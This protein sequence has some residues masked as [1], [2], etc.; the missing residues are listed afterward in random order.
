V[1]DCLAGEFAIDEPAG[2]RTDLFPSGFDCHLWAQ[3]FRGDQI[4]EQRKADA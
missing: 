2:D 3:F 4:G 1:E